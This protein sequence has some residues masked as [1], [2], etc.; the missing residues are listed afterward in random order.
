M[1]RP[2]GPKKKYFCSCEKICKTRREVSKSTFYLHN[3]KK[4]TQL[5]LSIHESGLEQPHASSQAGEQ[6]NDGQNTAGDCEDVVDNNEVERNQAERIFETSNELPFLD[7]EAHQGLQECQVPPPGSTPTPADYDN[8]N[9]P[10]E[11]YSNIEEIRVSQQFIE[12]LK[13]AKLN[14]G[15]LSNETIAA[16]LDPPKHSLKLEPNN[17]SDN[18]LLMCLRLFLGACNSADQYNNAIGAIQ[19]QFGSDNSIL[20]YDQLKRQIRQLTGIS[21]IIRDMCIKSCLAYT[22]PFSDDLM[23]RRCGEP[24]YDPV[25]HKSRQEFYTI[26]IGPAIQAF[27]RNH[28]TASDMNY[29]WSHVT[30]RLAEQ[31]EKGIIELI[32]DVTCGTDILAAVNQGHIGEHD[33]VLMVS[34]DGAQIYRNKQSDCWFYVWIILCFAPELRYTKRY[35]IPGGIMP[36]PFKIKI[37]ESYLSVGLHHVAAIN[38]AGGL[39]VW[40]AFRQE[41]VTSKLYIALATADGPGM[42]YLNGLVGH[43]GKYGCRLWCGFSGR[44]KPGAPMHYPVLFK[45]DNY[46]VSGCDHDDVSPALVRPIDQAHYERSLKLVINAKT[47]RVYEIQRRETGICKPSIFSGLPHGTYLGIPNMFPGDIMHLILNLADLLLGLWRGK[48]DCAHTTDT[49][50]AWPWAVLQGDVWNTHGQDVARCTPY[51]PGSFDRPPRNPAEKINSGYKAWEYLLYVFGLAP[52]LLYGVLPLPF[53]RSF[54]KMVAGIRFIYQ[55]R[56]HSKTQ[57]VAAHTYLIESVAEF[58]AL[59]VQRR[60][61]RIHFVRPIIHTLT[62]LSTEILRIGPGI[63]SSQWTMERQIGSLTSEIK[64]DSNPYANLSRRAV[65]RAEVICLK[66]T[67]PELDP[68][69]GNQIDLPRGA[70]DVGDGYILLRAVDTCKRAMTEAETN[71]FYQYLENDDQC[72]PNNIPYDFKPS[73]VRWARLRLPQKY[74]GQIA[75]SFW[76]ESLK[77]L[78]K[79]RTARR[80]KVCPGFL[81]ERAFYQISS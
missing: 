26:P 59:Y 57:V 29:F 54:C 3:K 68:L 58:E 5:A 11:Y 56:I 75:R 65:E 77:P 51:L 31:R 18:D 76:K 73:V 53:W 39:K 71:A 28:Q 37:V 43:S 62:H 52:G 8:D 55:R 49:I 64:Q 60:A 42:V 34:F 10:S 17:N 72:G 15:D 16:L 20:S 13:N 78:E 74:G 21:P 63:V 12:V 80:V 23:C 14:N 47:Q 38:K 44:H 41:T 35:V 48:L 81:A 36:G 24:R 32:D 4:S 69:A 2:S 79:T 46:T 61:D 9:D 30:E 25:T 7:F 45:P 1:A 27:K 6:Y 66:A 33:T 19:N 40:D 67:F 22:R 50:A 70:Q